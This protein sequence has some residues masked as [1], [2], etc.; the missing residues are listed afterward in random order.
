MRK[1]QVITLVLGLLM[2][3]WFTEARAQGVQLG[4]KDW[5]RRETI[6]RSLGLDPT[7]FS[8]NHTVSMGFS[9]QGGS[10]LMQSLYA[11]NISY[12]L[13]NPLTLSI[14]LGAQNSRFNYGGEPVSYND[15]IGGFTLDYRPSRDIFF[16][17]AFYRNPNRMWNEDI[18]SP[19]RVWPYGYES[20]GEYI[21]EQSVPT[22]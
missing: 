1:K 13:S 3:L 20:P 9:S 14:M 18:Y 6:S 11:T 5:L 8:I 4:F 15:L 17:L 10:S 16:R 2:I 21:I 19:Q 22:R 12:K 7:R